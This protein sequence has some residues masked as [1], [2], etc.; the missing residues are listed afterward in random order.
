MTTKIIETPKGVDRVIDEVEDA[1][2]TSLQ[3]APGNLE[4][5]SAKLLVTTGAKKRNCVFHP[6]TTN[7]FEE[8]IV[9]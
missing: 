5:P 8:R 7:G 6:F 4:P 1:N 2:L 9:T 3:A